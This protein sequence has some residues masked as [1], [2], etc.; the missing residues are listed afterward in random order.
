MPPF[1]FSYRLKGDTTVLNAETKALLVTVNTIPVDTTRAF[2]DLKGQV[3]VPLSWKDFLP[4]I[5]GVL[6][7]ALI[8]F[9]VYNYIKK[10]K[11]KIVEP[12][13]RIPKRPA[14]EIAFE[15]LRSLDETKL[16]Q[17]GNYKGYYTGLSDITRMF[18]ENRWS[19]AAMEMTT[20]EILKL[21]L[22]SDQNPD[23]FSK[24]KYL[25][26]LSDLVKFAKTIPVVYENEQCMQNALTFVEANKQLNEIKEEVA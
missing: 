25:L 4:Y 8:A 14:H 6:I 21:R 10:R 15:A 24:L 16:W 23:V 1:I 2:K 11:S 5:F 13:I 22:I 3:I 19:I 26:E 20:D 17:N 9:L 12:V 7:A 18:I